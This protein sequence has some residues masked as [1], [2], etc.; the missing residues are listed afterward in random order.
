MADYE[1]LYRRLAQEVLKRE[2]QIGDDMAAFVERLVKQLKVEDWQ[3]SGEAESALNAQLTAVNATLH[4]AIASAVAIASG[5]PTTAA[6]LQSETVLKQAEQAFAERWP[7]GLTLSDRVWR[8]QTDTRDGVQQQLQAAIRQGKSVNA[9][10]YDM[11]RAIER[12]TGSRFKI[13]TDHAD[14]WVKGL[15]ESALAMIH[16]PAAKA[17][18]QAT[19]GQVE[20]HISL[21]AKTGS[22]SAAERVL[23]QIKQAVAKGSEELADKAVKWWVYDQ[24]LYKLKRIAR[25][26]MATAGHR[27]VIASTEADDTVIGYQWRLSASHPAADICDYYANIEMGLGK[28]IWS[29]DA[30]PR[31]KAHPHCMCLLIPR[32]TPIAQRGSKNYAEFIANTTP[33]RRNDLLPGWAKNLHALGMPLDKLVSGNGLMTRAALQDQLGAD[34]F[35]ALTALSKA[36]VDQK[37]PENK[38]KL[39]L[40][41]TKDTLASLQAHADVPEVKRFLADLEQSGYRVDSLTWH[42][43]RYKF[44]FGDTLASP[45]ELNARFSAVLNDKSAAVYPTPGGRYAVVSKKAGRMAFVHGNG[46]R[47]SVYTYTD[48]DLEKLGNAAWTIDKLIT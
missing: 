29:K 45:A 10:V 20:E 31:H 35:Q 18:W 16:D 15:H 37:W 13:V 44:H 17:Q 25:T 2:G 3:L 36:A 47:I 21:L 8:W 12:G 30:V 1:Q 9:V 28:G 40:P 27:A 34:K 38:L 5:L 22:R 42:Y 7:D 14:D 43:F 24:Q 26:E 4:D 39:K 41:Q 46:Q 6:N 48:A 33:E 23:D 32:V 11:Q 19:V